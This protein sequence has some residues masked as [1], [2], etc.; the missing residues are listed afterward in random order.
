M[1]NKWIVY[2]HINKQNQKKYF[3]MTCRELSARSGYNGEKYKTS[4]C[5]YDAILKYG[6][7]E[8]EHYILHD[9]LTEEEAETYEQYYIDI[10]DAYN[11]AF[12]YN[13][14]R[15][16]RGSKGRTYLSDKAR[17]SL[18]RTHTGNKYAL[19]HT[20]SKES[21]EIMRQCKLGRKLTKEH[22]NKIV[23]SR[24]KSFVCIPIYQYTLDGVFVK[25]W[26]SSQDVKAFGF[27][28]CKVVECCKGRR[29]KHGGFA[30]SYYPK[31]EDG[32]EKELQDEIRSS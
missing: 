11:R 22:I 3:G 6:W 17:E 23:E 8:F 19:G 4:P 13:I 7:D 12:G 29:N 15:G 2:V 18:K 28:T 16:G 32:L 10:Y 26:R 14:T 20:V 1:K 31:H 30:W 27:L 5:F 25:K 9:N 24:K 21:R